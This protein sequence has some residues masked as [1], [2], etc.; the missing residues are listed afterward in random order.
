L[1]ERARVAA[2]GLQVELEPQRSA[3]RVAEHGLG[4][5]FERLAGL[6]AEHQARA[7][8]R[9]GVGRGQ[10]AVGVREALERHGRE[11]D[12]M[13]ERAPEQ[14]AA[15]VPARERA[16]HARRQRECVPGAAVGAQRD[17]VGRAAAEVGPDR[18]V[19][20]RTRMALVVGEGEEV[21][22]QRVPL[23]RGGHG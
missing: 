18:R 3:A 2:V 19:Q 12:G 20:A 16:Q 7:E 13:R 17:L 6:R 15:C 11:Q 8:R 4:H 23:R 1:H 5:G 9:G 22:G 10:F 21:G 14:L